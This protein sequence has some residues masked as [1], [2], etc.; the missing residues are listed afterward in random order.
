[1]VAS[2][3]YLGYQCWRRHSCI[4]KYLAHM[5]IYIYIYEY[6]HIYIYMLYIY[7]IYIYICYV[8]LDVHVYCSRGGW[9]T[10]EKV[11]AGQLWARWAE[12]SFAIVSP[13]GSYMD[14]PM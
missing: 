1:M 2:V 6:I 10:P 9:V 4:K 3:E 7:A 12:F 14:N 13:A 11:K 5:C 8:D